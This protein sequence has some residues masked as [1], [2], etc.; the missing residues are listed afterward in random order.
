MN[1]EDPDKLERFWHKPEGA[2]K[3]SPDADPRPALT[4]GVHEDFAPTNEN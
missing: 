2:P 1:W 4:A 3:L